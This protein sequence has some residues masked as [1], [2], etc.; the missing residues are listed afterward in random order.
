MLDR[1]YRL[2][3]PAE[4]VTLLHPAYGVRQCVSPEQDRR[5]LVQELPQLVGEQVLNAPIR[6]NPVKNR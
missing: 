4:V 2:L 6:V 5:L 3:L 1:R